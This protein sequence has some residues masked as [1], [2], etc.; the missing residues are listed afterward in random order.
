VEQEMSYENTGLQIIQENGQ[1]SECSQ[2]QSRIKAK[3]S[4]EV[5]GT[6]DYIVPINDSINDSIN[7]SI[8]DS[9][10]D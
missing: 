9:I 8:N 1:S 2:S 6:D 5:C 7:G 4:P 10:S 3:F